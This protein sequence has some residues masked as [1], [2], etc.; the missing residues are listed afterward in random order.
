M[1]EQTENYESPQV[2]IVEANVEKGFANTLSNGYTGTADVPESGMG[3][4]EW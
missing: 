4:G 2:E 3:E 1:K